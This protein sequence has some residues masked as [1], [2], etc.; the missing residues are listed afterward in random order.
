MLI[1]NVYTNKSVYQSEEIS[2]S[3]SKPCPLS[4]GR[5]KLTIKAFYQCVSMTTGTPA[6]SFNLELQLFINYEHNCVS[7]TTETPALSLNTNL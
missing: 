7:M 2:N 3:K 5:D 4:I 1:L 6:L